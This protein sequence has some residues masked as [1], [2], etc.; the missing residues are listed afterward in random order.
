MTTASAASHSGGPPPRPPAQPETV[1]GVQLMQGLHHKPA[2]GFWAD[3]WEQVLRRRAAVLGLAWISIVAFFACFAPLIA[4]GHPYIMRQIGEDGAVTSVSSPLYRH[5]DAA[6]KLLIIGAVVAVVWVFGPWR[7]PRSTRLLMFVLAAVQAGITVIAARFFAA[8]MVQPGAGAWL[9]SLRDSSSTPWLVSGSFALAAAVVFAFV[10]ST[11]RVPL[12]IGAVAIVAVVSAWAAAS[13]WFMPPMVFDY[14]DREAAGAITAVYAPIPWSPNQ[15]D[16]RLDLIDPGFT[17]AQGLAGI[18]NGRTLAAKAD[19]PANTERSPRF[20]LGTD[21]LGQDV[22][23]QLL[24]A[25]RLS[26]SIGLVSTGIAVLIGVTIGSIMGYFGGVVDT[27]LFR[28]VEIFMSVPVL[29]LL[30]VAAGVLPPELRS[31][32]VI[33]AIIGCFTWTG[34]ARFVRAEFMKL[35]NQDFVQAAAATGLPLRSILFKHML[36]NGVTPVLVDA[37]FAVAVAILFEAILSYL[38]L[39]P[40]DQASW[41]RLLSEAT[42]QIGSFVPHLA[43]APGA[44]IFLTVL[45]FTLVNEALRDA[46]DPKL[47]KARV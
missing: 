8:Q 40:P 11:D 24:H 3:A 1:T 9:R 45:S 19:H 25:C 27:V 39:G 7:L 23:S 32:Y 5:L 41:G 33:M 47:K 29:F 36:P 10:R 12:R 15:R 21:S 37:S 26:I 46:I 34:A 17:R 2:K 38:G 4:N 44:A 16:T 28:I 31:T 42:T 14:R 20:I 43:I 18:K 30:V 35:R 22:A 13:S 6:D